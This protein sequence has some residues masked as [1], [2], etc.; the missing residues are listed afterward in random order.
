MD[1]CS[2][3]CSRAKARWGSTE[4]KVSDGRPEQ[5]A[6][7]VPGPEQPPAPVLSPRPISTLILLIQ[8]GVHGD[9]SLGGSIGS[10][11][12]EVFSIDLHT[13]LGRE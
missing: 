13:H 10:L 1:A 8:A 9:E 11:F 7:A 2:A 12:F 5:T 6:V 3:L 4:G